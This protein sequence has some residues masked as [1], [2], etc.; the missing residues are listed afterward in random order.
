MLFSCD[1]IEDDRYHIIQKED[2]TVEFPV[3]DKN[4]V[5]RKILLDEFTGHMCTNCP[6]GH[7]ILNDLHS[8]YGDTL[9]IMGIHYGA[10]AKPFGSTFSYDFRTEAGN[11]IGDYFNIDGIPVAVVNRELKSGGWQREQWSSVVANVD[12]TDV[13]AAI[14]IVNQYDPENKIVKAN[15][16]VT[17][18][19]DYPHPL[20][21]AF[22]MIEDNVIKPQ[23]NG[24]QTVTEYTHNH[25]LRASF[26]PKPF[27]EI[28]NNGEILLKDG[29][30][31]M[32]SVLK[33]DNLDLNL[34]NC[35][36][37]AVLYDKANDLVLQV[38]SLKIK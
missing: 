31:T 1:K 34:D 26:S 9:V 6:A 28:L 19:T 17:M 10:L 24:T 2:V 7:A 37:V 21:L 36:V 11:A 35:S 18:L 8:R 13:S 30:Y 33:F 25:V 23:K 15:A 38:E 12:R 20:Q 32:A 5:Y 27:G 16:K 14:Q 22:Y 29:E 3:L 4:S